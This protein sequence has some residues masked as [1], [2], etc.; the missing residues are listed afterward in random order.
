MCSLWISAP[1]NVPALEYRTL[2]CIS[3]CLPCPLPLYT[4]S[5]F[6]ALSAGSLLLEASP[7]L[8][9]RR[10]PLLRGIHHHHHVFVG[11]YLALP[12]GPCSFKLSEGR[13]HVDFAPVYS[14]HMIRPSMPDVH[15]GQQPCSPDKRTCLLYK[16]VAPKSQC[17]SHYG[18]MRACQVLRRAPF[19]DV[20]GCQS[21]LGLCM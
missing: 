14:Q 12:L 17:Q 3:L 2:A 10:V 7:G 9:G 15:Q 4:P 6:R 5:A 13:D 16:M 11:K 8:A 20:M 19:S 1:S 21:S 18:N